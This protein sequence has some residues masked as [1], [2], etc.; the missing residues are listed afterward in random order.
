MTIAITGATGHIGSALTP[1]LEAEGYALRLLVRPG[2]S[3]TLR[4]PGDRAP[5]TIPGNLLN[6]ASLA[7]LVQGADAVI[8]L[9]AR[10]SLQ[11]G[12]DEETMRVNVEGTRLLLEAAKNAGVRRFI[13]LSSVTAFAQAPYQERMDETRGPA[14]AGARD[15]EHSKVLSQA[16]ALGYGGL[17]LAPSAVIGPFDRRPSAMGRA[18]MDIYRGKVPALFPGGVDFVDVRDVAEAIRQALNR[19]TPGTAYLLS[20]RWV[21]LKD[22]GNGLGRKIPVLPPWLILGTLPLVKGWAKMTGQTPLYTRQAV[23]HVLCS[24]QKIDSAKA[25]TQLGWHP[26]PFEETL[27]DTIEWF[28]KNGML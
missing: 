27:K 13:H 28:Q 25:K 12:D 9:A 7:I 17:V 21:S 14:T 5:Q 20:G 24:N 11:D 10:I 2:A 16:L 8:H 4:G 18:I 15:Y 1:L 19:G 22:L 3:P 23:H 6:P 26:R